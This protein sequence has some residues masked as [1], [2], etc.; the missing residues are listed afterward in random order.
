[1]RAVLTK[2][3]EKRTPNEYACEVAASRDLTG[4]EGAENPL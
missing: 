3:S 2:L 4:P 1:M